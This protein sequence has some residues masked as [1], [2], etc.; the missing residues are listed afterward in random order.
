MKKN[1]VLQ[2]I[3][4]I[5]CLKCKGEVQFFFSI[6]TYVYQKKFKLFYKWGKPHNSD[7][8]SIRKI[9]DFLIE[10]P[11]PIQRKFGTSDPKTLEPHKMEF[12]HEMTFCF[13]I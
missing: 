4:A 3:N 10:V 2:P 9:A 6:Y 11:M 13:E 7:S 12:Y 5:A 1:M 8:N